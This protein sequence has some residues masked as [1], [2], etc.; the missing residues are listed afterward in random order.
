MRTK[1]T[2]AA[3]RELAPEPGIVSDGRSD[4]DLKGLV[5][6]AL[7]ERLSEHID[8]LHAAF[9]RLVTGAMVAWKQWGSRT[10]TW[11]CF[12]IRFKPDSLSI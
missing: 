9:A 8:S 5:L 12:W 2:R 10:P 7:D 11:P 6:R 1:L 3:I 4:A